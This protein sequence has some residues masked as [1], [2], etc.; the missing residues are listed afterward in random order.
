LR[1][2][3][4]LFKE[5][6]IVH[7]QD[8]K[9][10]TQE[11]KV[12]V[13]KLGDMLLGESPF[14]ELVMGNTAL[15]RGMVEAGVRV[16][17]SYPGSPTP[18]IAT[19][20]ASMGRERRP[21]HFEFCVNEKVAVEVAY[22]AAVNGRPSVAFFK[23]VGLNVAS[24]TFV[25]LNHMDI[26]GGLVVI[27][28]DD[29]GA[30]S[31]QNE[32]DN[33]HLARMSYTPVLE[34]ASPS[35]AYV[36]LL[37][38]VSMAR[39]HRMAVMLRLTTHVCHA[40]EM[41]SFGGWSNPARDDTP[42]FD[43]SGGS[44]IPIGAMVARM[45]KRAIER[46]GALRGPDHDRV[47]D[48]GNGRR[49]IITAGLPFLSVLDALD[50][51]GG[52]PD[53]LKL[54][55]VH[56]LDRDGI[57][58]FLRSHDEV[59]VLEEL[60]DFMEQAVK[61]VAHDSGG[62]TRVLGKEQT[63]DWIGEFTP[64]RVREIL[65][66]FW[67]DLVD[68]PASV[69]GN[70]AAPVRFPQM[71]PGCGH[72]S[73]FFA[74]GKALRESDITV[75]D[76]GCH[77]LGFLPPHEI[78]RLLMSM[79]ASTGIGQGLSLFNTER[80]VVAFL[81]DSTFFHAGIPGVI[82]AVFNNHRLTLIVMENGTTA[83]TGHQEHPG[84]GRNFDDPTERIPIRRVLEGLG[85]QNIAEVD[86]YNQKALTQAV[87]EA[88]DAP[89]LSVVIAKHP[90]MLKFSREQRRKPGFVQRHVEVSQEKCT[91][92]RECIDRFGCPSFMRDSATGRVTT[93][94]DLC[95]GDGSCIQTCPS[96]AIG[97]VAPGKESR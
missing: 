61:A 55:M 35:E 13:K 89:G 66:R 11:G 32:Q 18:E 65:H 30:H 53:I 90:C 37:K 31:S 59:L 12:L 69:A 97:A 82:N 84:T 76:I 1:I 16:V 68:A 43:G 41:V 44:H 10:I 62:S 95:I 88:L 33:R 58:G 51:A 8:C 22:G 79:G 39:K 34:P 3:T 27:V 50:G 14:Q 57:A 92:A 24:D 85:I 42:R 7:Y 5:A 73:A 64:G 56:P 77:T 81:G 70:L 54:G 94:T 83:M 6:L 75:A 74:I 87:G 2:A 28:G 78:G 29:P 80:R 86:T 45:K 91:L 93:N 17:T 47:V 46:L 4:P 60:D 67:P 49:G 20:I 96:E 71:C 23:S 25:Q 26:P 63:E 19:A 21:F 9:C 36:F 40:K 48:N 52:K 72:R 15:V 38:A